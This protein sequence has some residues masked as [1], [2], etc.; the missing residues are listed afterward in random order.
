MVVVWASHWQTYLESPILDENVMAKNIYTSEFANRYGEK[1]TF[2]YDYAIGKG[3]LKGSDVD[4][5]SYDVVDGRA[6]D[7]ILNNE[8]MLWLRR[9]WAEA[10]AQSP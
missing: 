6:S 4:W 9:A 1:W 7:L 8:E 3:I 10:I 2:E 5:Q